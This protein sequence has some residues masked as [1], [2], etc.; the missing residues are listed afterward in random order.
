[1]PDYFA[2]IEATGGVGCEQTP[3]NIRVVN[4]LH[5]PV[6]IGVASRIGSTE[7]GLATWRLRVR[8]SDVPGR[9]VI[10]GKWFVADL[11]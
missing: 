1:M 6:P 10:L 2:Q 5:Q 8:G 3:A 4:S 7:E 9:W 11:G